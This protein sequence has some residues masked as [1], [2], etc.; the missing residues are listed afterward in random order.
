M[1]HRF[2][3]AKKLCYLRT[4]GRTG[5]QPGL[6]APKRER[7]EGTLQGTRFQLNFL[8]GIEKIGDF[9]IAPKGT[10]QPLR[11]LTNKHMIHM[12]TNRQRC[13]DNVIFAQGFLYSHGNTLH[14]I[15]FCRVGR[16]KD[17]FIERL[18]MLIL[19]IDTVQEGEVA[20]L[21][22]KNREG[23]PILFSTC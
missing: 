8:W 6:S 12:P 13:N 22:Y 18:P 9:S 4:I 10:T 21:R 19:A 17:V 5:A 3:T 14:K 15:A 7:K 20:P 23:M 11:S 1:V 16:S 2:F